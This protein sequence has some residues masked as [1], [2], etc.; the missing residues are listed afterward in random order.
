MSREV[1]I[2]SSRGPIAGLYDPPADGTRGAVLMVGG[3][4]GGFEGPAEG[5]YPTL[6]QDLAGAGIGALRL[7][8]RLH[9][10]PND[11]AEGTFDAIGGLRYLAGQGV[12]RVGLVGHS[13][14][15]AVVIEAGWQAGSAVQ[16]ACVATL[17]TQTAGAQLVANLAPVP[18]LLVHGLEDAR[19]SPECSRLLHQ[20]AGEPKRLRLLEGA[21]HSLRQRR[22]EVRQLLLDWLREHLDTSD[23]LMSGGD[24]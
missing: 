12:E 6:A 8:F 7:D 18:L 16:V 22:E 9:V 20:M 15:G 13:F 10:F 14:G 11:V 23:G 21:T 19:L 2:E 4:D 5:L 3:A 1:T 24:Q 17:A